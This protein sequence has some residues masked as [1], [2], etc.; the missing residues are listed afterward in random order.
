MAVDGP[1]SPKEG[2]RWTIDRLV[3]GEVAVPFPQGDG[4][5]A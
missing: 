2:G 3:T 1:S 5:A 4:F